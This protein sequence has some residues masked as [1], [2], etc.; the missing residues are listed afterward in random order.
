MRRP[1]RNLAISFL[2][3]PVLA[4]AHEPI[5]TKLTWTQEVSRIIYKHSI[6][7]RLRDAI[8]ENVRSAH[9]SMHFED[10][11]SRSP[12]MKKCIRIMLR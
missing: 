10:S 7:P 9:T 4:S 1:T 12:A 8:W 2:L 3:L 5:T 6:F 11:V